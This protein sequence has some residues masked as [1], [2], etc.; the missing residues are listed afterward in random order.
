MATRNAKVDA[1]VDRYDIGTGTAGGVVRIY[2]GAQ[3][4]SANDAPSGT[5]LASVLLANPAFGAA[6]SGTATATDPASVNAS[7]SGTAGW[8]RGVDRDGATVHDGSC[9]VSVAVTAVAS[10]DV[11]TTSSAHGLAVGQVI[12]VAAGV[13]GVAAGPYVVLSVP[14]STTFTIGVYGSTT[15]VNVTADG[16]TT[17]TTADM[18]LSTTTLVAGS[19]VDI[20][21]YT[22]TQ[23]AG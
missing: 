13:T 11:F 7:V 2:S 8:F 18:A 17:F 1:A 22:Y 15:P 19:P 6:A 21:L 23:P 5:L 20:T 3:P 12:Q 4:A 16:A 14:T 10:T 9:G